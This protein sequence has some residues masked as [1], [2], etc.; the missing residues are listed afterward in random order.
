M[1]RGREKRVARKVCADLAALE[2]IRYAVAGVLGEVVAT[3]GDG[4]VGTGVVG[5]ERV[6]AGEVAGV[7]LF[8]VAFVFFAGAVTA[9]G[10]VAS[11]AEV[12][13]RRGRGLR[14]RW[15]AEG[16]TGGGRVGGKA[17]A[18]ESTGSARSFFARGR[19]RLSAAGREPR[20][21]G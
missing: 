1:A 2:A 6:V 12:V 18:R 4:G 13:G 19:A 11:G 16:R 14:G 21:R 20:A 10:V 7:F 5:E 17:S 3:G 15:V 8:A 9:G